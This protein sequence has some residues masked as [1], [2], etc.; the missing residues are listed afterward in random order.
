[1]VAYASFLGPLDSVSGHYDFQCLLAICPISLL[2]EQIDKVGSDP[3]MSIV[4]PKE[5]YGNYYTFATPLDGYNNIY[6]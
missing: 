5:Q 6:R 2:S 3:M 1:M 4:T